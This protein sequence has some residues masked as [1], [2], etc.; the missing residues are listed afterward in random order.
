MAKPTITE[1]DKKRVLAALRDTPSFKTGIPAVSAGWRCGRAG[2][3][4]AESVLNILLDEGKVEKIDKRGD[5]SL[6]RRTDDVLW[7]AL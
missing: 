4:Y 2:T 5:D 3:A 1:L 7:R 6:P